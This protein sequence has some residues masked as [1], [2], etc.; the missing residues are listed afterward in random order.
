MIPY[1]QIDKN[2]PVS[3]AFGQVGLPWARLLVSIGAL[4]GIT[5]VLLA[6]LLGLPRIFL[7]MARDGL[8]PEK[9]FMVRVLSVSAGCA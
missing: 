9:F 7:A 3:T 5:S 8:L 6:F 1:D 4:T 2:A